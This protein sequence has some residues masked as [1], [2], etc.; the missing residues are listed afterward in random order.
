MVTAPLTVSAGTNIK[1]LEAMA[2]GKALVATP[3]GCGGL[4]LQ[5]GTEVLIKSD[6][7]AFAEAVCDVLSNAVLRGS[8]SAR[9]RR[10]AVEH[11]SWEV[12]A[13]GAYRSYLA[14]GSR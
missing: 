1:V 7:D 13:D 3:L 9:G 8:L 12:I 11:F 2:C 6:W 14:L 10:T 4:G 5:D